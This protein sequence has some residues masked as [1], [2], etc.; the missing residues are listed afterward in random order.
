MQSGKDGIG[1]IH[2]ALGLF[3]SVA[4]STRDP[5]PRY[6][7]GVSEEDPFLKAEKNNHNLIKCFAMPGNESDMENN[8]AFS[9]SMTM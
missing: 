4:K 3:P 1:D 6:E 9:D 5:N 2:S 7:S 8:L